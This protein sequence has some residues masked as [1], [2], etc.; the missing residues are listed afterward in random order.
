MLYRSNMRSLSLS[1]SAPID[2]AQPR[3]GTA[4]TVG[5]EHIFSEVAIADNAVGQLINTITS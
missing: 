1:P 3:N 2:K 4:F 5:T